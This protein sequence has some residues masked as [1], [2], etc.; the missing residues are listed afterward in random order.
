M[1]TNCFI[2]AALSAACLIGCHAPTETAKPA[3]AQVQGDQITLA[4]NAPQLSALSVEPVEVRKSNVIQFNGRLVWNDDAT[5]RVFS[6]LAGRVSK[7]SAEVGEP[8]AAGALL[9][10]ID[11][12]D[13]GQAQADL[14]RAEADFHLA[15]R[16]LNR[17]RDLFEHGAAPKKDL[18]GAEADYSRAQSEQQR[19]AARLVLYGGGVQAVDQLFHLNSPLS[20]VVV[21]KNVTPGQEVRPDQMLANA[22]QLFAPLFVIT[23]PS[24]LWVWIDVFEGE[25]GQLKRGQALQIHARAYPGKV[26]EGK[27]DLIT[28]TLDPTT[29]TVRVRGSVDNRA[30]LLKSEMYVTVD[31]PEKDTTG[32][33]VPAK[34]VFLRG[35]KYYVFTEDTRGQFSRR[36]VTAGSEQD[37]RITITTGLRIGQNVVTQGCLLLE[38]LLEGGAS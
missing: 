8:V 4:T 25:L 35:E 15:D 5:V 21:E 34:S 26:F 17:I 22:P 16:T 24:R 12:P 32:V 31:I 38:E 20:G 19:A 2:L 23:D 7:I 1:K 37:G 3:A 10:L 9:S 6:P 33:E 28:D 18:D 13:F 27:L 30:R 14:H 29:R 36:E 11:S